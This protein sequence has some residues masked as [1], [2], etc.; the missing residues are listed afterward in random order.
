MKP[1]PPHV[2]VYEVP[3]AEG[4]LLVSVV[5]LGDLGEGLRGWDLG[6]GTCGLE[7]RV[8][9]GRL[10]CW[11]RVWLSYSHPRG[12]TSLQFR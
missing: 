5:R 7:G 8:L 3:E 10:C 11:A 2:D 1:P 12:S 6:V 9:K 4:L